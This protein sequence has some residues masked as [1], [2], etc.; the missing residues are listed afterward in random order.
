M[1]RRAIHTRPSMFKA[2]AS[3]AKYNITSGGF[4]VR[5]MSSCHLGPGPEGP[6]PGTILKKL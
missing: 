5:S 6:L 3:T 2:I 1:N 4:N